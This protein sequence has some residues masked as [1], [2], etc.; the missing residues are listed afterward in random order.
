MKVQHKISGEVGTLSKVKNGGELIVITD[1][2]SYVY[3][4]LAEVVE[5][6][7]DYVE[8]ID[9]WSINITNN[10][11]F[12]IIENSKYRVFTDTDI[13]N[14][15]L[16][17]FKFKTEKEAEKAVERL[18]A[19][20]RLKD[21]RFRF[22]KWTIPEEPKTPHIKLVIEAEMDVPDSPYDLDLLFADEE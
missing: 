2:R 13:K 14:L 17:G 20:K 6:W 5:Y 9:I 8:P 12:H 19:C 7:Q 4:T 15:E 10:K 11:P 22:N 18:K 3:K 1:T 21:K 16:I